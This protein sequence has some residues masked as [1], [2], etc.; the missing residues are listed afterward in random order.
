M[1]TRT[2]GIQNICWFELNPKIG[3]KRGGGG[4]GVLKWKVNGNVMSKGSKNLILRFD[5]S[6]RK[7][8]LTS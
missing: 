7:E 4:I 8:K 2:K 3:R 1:D 5:L 6:L